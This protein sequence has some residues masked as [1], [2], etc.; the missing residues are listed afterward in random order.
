L[1]CVI[2]WGL[3]DLKGVTRPCSPSSHIKQ[4]R[5]TRIRG[6]PRGKDLYGLFTLS[7]PA[8]ILEDRASKHLCALRFGDPHTLQNSLPSGFLQQWIMITHSLTSPGSH[9]LTS[10]SYHSLALNVDQKWIRG[11][12]A[13]PPGNQVLGFR[14]E[15]RVFV[16]GFRVGSRV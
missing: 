4:N 8:Q 12:T 2:P 6:W 5:W 10:E 9:F 14:G 3:L 7:R 15:T 11:P 13:G 16:L 1:D